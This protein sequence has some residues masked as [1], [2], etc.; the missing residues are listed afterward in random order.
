MRPILFDHKDLNSKHQEIDDFLNRFGYFVFDAH[1]NFK[2]IGHR[3]TQIHT[4][5]SSNVFVYIA[6]DLWFRTKTKE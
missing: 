3:F 1:P 2:L 5:I 4:D 6:F